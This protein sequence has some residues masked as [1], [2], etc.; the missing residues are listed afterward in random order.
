MKRCRMDEISGPYCK[1]DTYGLNFQHYLFKMEL[2]CVESC[3]SNITI[4][5]T[6]SSWDGSSKPEL[7]KG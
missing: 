1:L 5:F 2:D 7:L 3:T 6:K 4:G